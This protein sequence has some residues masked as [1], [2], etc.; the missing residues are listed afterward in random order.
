MANSQISHWRDENQ[1][2]PSD[3]LPHTSPRIDRW[4]E[5]IQWNVVSRNGLG[6]IWHAGTTLADPT[7][8]HVVVAVTLP[9]GTVLA[10]KIVAAGAPGV[11]GPSI[12]Y[13]ATTEP[14]QKWTLSYQAGMRTVTEEQRAGGLLSDEAH[15]PVRIELQ[16][17]AAHPLWIP[18][19]SEK[20][21][22]WGHFHHEQAVLAAGTISVGG[23]EYA[24][25]GVGHRDHSIGPRDMSRLRRAFWGNGTFPSG[26]AFATM[27]GDYED[28]QFER[29]AIFDNA[30]QRD[31]HL[32]NWSR[33]ENA[34][35]APLEFALT[36]DLGV[37]KRVITGRC[38]SGI[39]FTVLDG[40]EFGLGTDL[41]SPDRY[42]LT[43]LFTEWD[44]DGE[45]G[46]GYVDRGALIGLLDARH[47][48]R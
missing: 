8:W 34:V 15:L 41:S 23:V 29:A 2:E 36:L 1:I 45:Q 28:C 25:D 37:E 43:C 13:L 48:P 18:A 27:Q 38:T 10:G 12:A 16:L 22:D 9:D 14:F 3:D 47:P 7:M 32:V 5:N 30:G 31:A 24:M 11:F 42:V 19:G 17:R 26:W 40:A 46:L 44:C 6:V 35:G 39:N 20:H 21:G 4:T 33:L